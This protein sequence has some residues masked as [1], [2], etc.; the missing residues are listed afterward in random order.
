MSDMHMQE[1]QTA[2]LQ[3]TIG[4]YLAN[5]NTMGH[6]PTLFVLFSLLSLGFGLAG[7][8]LCYLVITTPFTHFS[9]LPLLTGLFPLSYS[10][11]SLTF[12]WLSRRILK[13]HSLPRV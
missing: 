8:A 10:I 13:K 3:K 1:K 5:I 4:L 12:L 9:I 7:G 2:P 11:N 6:I